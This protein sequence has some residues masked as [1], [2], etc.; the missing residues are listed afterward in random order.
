MCV[1]SLHILYHQPN[2]TFNIGLG[3]LPQ[4]CFF[5]C[6]SRHDNLLADKDGVYSSMWLQQQTKADEGTLSD[7]G[8]GSST[9]VNKTNGKD[10]NSAVNKPADSHD[11]STD[12]GDKHHH[13]H[14]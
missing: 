3:K 5:F 4:C 12:K 14:H 13:H 2:I 9:E 11:K 1:F 10:S 8:E 6:L 7:S